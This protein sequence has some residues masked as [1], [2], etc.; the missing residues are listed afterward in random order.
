[1]VLAGVARRRF[2]HLERPVEVAATEDRAV[3]RIPGEEEKGGSGGPGEEHQKA[4]RRRPPGGIEPTVPHVTQAGKEDEDEACHPRGSG[5]EESGRLGGQRAAVVAQAPEPR[6]RRHADERSQARG[7]RDRPAVVSKRQGPEGHQEHPQP[8][9]KFVVVVEHARGDDGHRQAANRPSGSD[10]EEVAGE[11]TGGGSEPVELAV[12]DHAG[13]QQR[14][15]M[16]CQLELERGGVALREDLPGDDDTERGEGRERPP[17]VPGGVVEGDDE[18]HQVDPQRQHPQQR[19]GRHVLAQP[20]R[21]RHQEHRRDRRECHPEHAVAGLF[22]FEPGVD[23][24]VPGLRTASAGPHPRG[25]G[26]AGRGEAGQADRPGTGLGRTRQPRLDHRRVGEEG[27]ERPGIGEGIEP[28]GRQARVD[29]AEPP[30]EERSG[31][32]ED[33]KRQADRCREEEEDRG[34]GVIAGA[35]APAFPRGDGEEGEG[36]RETDAMDQRLPPRRQPCREE[37]GIGIARQQHPLEEEEAGCPDAG[38]TAIPGENV[39]PD[40]RLPDEEEEGPGEN[41]QRE[42]QHGEPQTIP[43]H[44]TIPVKRT[45]SRQPF[46]G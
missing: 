36:Q 15:E 8:R 20:G 40:Q 12:A 21:R 24:P 42:R 33:D 32:R 14:R 27:E 5:G 22:V 41:R 29:Q 43:G 25:T 2:D 4:P 13:D 6:N 30:L 23:S 7:Q 35:G 16:P 18:C 26:H 11:V 19:Y 28:V 38:T 9:R 10:G 46:G 45:T 39:L 44:Q 34:D 17:A 37:V 1:M 3:A 31:G